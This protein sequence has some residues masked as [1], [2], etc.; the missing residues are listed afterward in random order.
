MYNHQR[1]K[2]ICMWKFIFI[3]YS[4]VVGQRGSIGTLMQLLRNAQR[5]SFKHMSE[6]VAW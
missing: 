1:A 6:N 5:D 2:V 3:E 4:P